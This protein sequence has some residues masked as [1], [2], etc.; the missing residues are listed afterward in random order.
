MTALHIFC[1]KPEKTFAKPFPS[2]II[3]F[4]IPQSLPT[5]NKYY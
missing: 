5:K 2:A 1:A 4:F 3:P